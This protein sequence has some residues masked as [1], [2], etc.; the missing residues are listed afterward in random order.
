MHNDGHTIGSGA[1]LPP[2]RWWQ[3]FSRSLFHLRVTGADGARRTY[4]VDVT[5]AGDEDGVV[6]AR[7][8]EDGFLHATSKVPAAFPVPGGT[9][10]VAVSGF[11]LRRSHYVRADGW[12][13]Q[14]APDPASGGQTRA[15]GPQASGDQS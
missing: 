4:S 13:Q 3:M 8:Y 7:L 6:R 15:P 11:G 5:H 9:I 12:E 2:Y 10:E 14:L 1:P